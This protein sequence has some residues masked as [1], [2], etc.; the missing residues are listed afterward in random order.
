MDPAQRR[1][2]SAIDKAP[3]QNDKTPVVRA[4]GRLRKRP[5]KSWQANQ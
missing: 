5:I 3:A 1:Q 2:V 4:A